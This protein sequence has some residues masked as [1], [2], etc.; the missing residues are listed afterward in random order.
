MKITEVQTLSDFRL[1]L[2]FDDGTTG[3]A[4]LSQLVGRG[5]FEAW[6]Q[7][8][9]FEQVRITPVGALE[10]PGEIDLCPDAL[11]L[12]TTGKRPEEAFPALRGQLSHA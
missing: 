12:Q 3:V 2:R 4:D 5:V 6:R 11:Y 8:G 10:W 9:V 1:R 7:P